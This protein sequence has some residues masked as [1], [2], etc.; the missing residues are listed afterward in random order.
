MFVS[1]DDP[2]ART[3]MMRRVDSSLGLQF[4]G[5]LGGFGV[6]DCRFVQALNPESSTQKESG[7][8]LARLL[9][10]GSRF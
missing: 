6:W 5:L 2:T 10:Q 8:N 4:V 7:G 1:C 3:A 9:R